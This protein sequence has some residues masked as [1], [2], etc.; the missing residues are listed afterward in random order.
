MTTSQEEGNSDGDEGEA[1][2][3]DEQVSPPRAP[4]HHSAQGFRT[5]K[6][7]FPLVPLG[8]VPGPSTSRGQEG[9]TLYSRMGECLVEAIRNPRKREASR[10]VLD[11]FSGPPKRKCDP[12]H[13]IL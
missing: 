11:A 9:E 4:S 8:T 7:P 5:E 2:G 3:E 10:D 12:S 1:Q 13:I 6:G